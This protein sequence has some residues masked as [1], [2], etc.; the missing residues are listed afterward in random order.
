MTTISRRSFLAASGVGVAT[1]VTGLGTQLAV[2][3]S[4]TGSREKLV[5]LMLDGGADG[6]TLVPPVSMPSYYDNRPDIAVPQPNQNGGALPLTNGSGNGNVRFPSGLN[7]IFG[8]HPTL[9]PIFGQW[10]SGNL[11]FVVGSGLPGNSRSH[12]RSQVKIRA[13]SLDAVEGGWVARIMNARGNPQDSPLQAVNSSGNATQFVAGMVPRMGLIGNLNNAGIKGFQNNS[14]ATTALR[15]L[16]A[17]NDSVS[18]QGTR[19]INVIDS[20]QQLDSDRRPGYP[21]TTTGRRFSELATLLEADLGVEAAAFASGGWDHHGRL[22]ARMN[23]DGA[24]LGNALGAFI[25][26]TKLEGINLM[27]ITE[28][29]RTIN[30]NGNAGTDHGKGFTAMVMGPG[31]QGGVYGEDYPSAFPNAR[32]HDLAVLTDYRK[33]IT[34]VATGRLG[35]DGDDVGSIF[36]GYNFNAP[37]GLTR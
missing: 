2:A 4:P 9:E 29:G 14:L 13:G 8:L 28:F 34:E 32:R 33:M 22:T 35:L 11:A 1:V 5:V 21:N 24:E 25:N 7:G 37:L 12:F 15:V 16:H 20:I 18:V 26:D 19:L 36:P 31:I 27:V 10:Q 23:N 17:R 30:Q 3:Q 6:M